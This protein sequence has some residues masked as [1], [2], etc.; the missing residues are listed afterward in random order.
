VPDFWRRSRLACAS[1]PPKGWVGPW[2][3]PAHQRA[4]PHGCDLVLCRYARQPAVEAFRRACRRARSPLLPAG[5]GR[6]YPS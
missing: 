3:T 5:S 4:V 6:S 1:S 2:S